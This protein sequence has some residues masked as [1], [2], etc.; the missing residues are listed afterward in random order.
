MIPDNLKLKT[1]F[2]ESSILIES[3][4]VL[5]THLLA[6]LLQ[7]GMYLGIDRTPIWTTRVDRVL[8]SGRVSFFGN[9][10]PRDSSIRRVLHMV[11]SK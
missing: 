11:A 1:Q 5:N 4:Q 3:P 9:I 8:W 10:Q 6:K 2:D 7:I